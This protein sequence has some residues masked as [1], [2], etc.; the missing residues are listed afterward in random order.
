MEG[1]PERV[2]ERIPGSGRSRVLHHG[3]VGRRRELHALRRDLRQGRQLHVVQGL[4]GLGKS[5]FCIEALK[6]YRR[7]GRAALTLWCAE[8]ETSAVPTEGL[9][10]QLTAAAAP[11]AGADWEA[12]LAALDQAA[13]ADPALQSPARRLV[14]LL[15]WL[16]A[17]DAQPPLVLYLDNLESLLHRPDAEDGFGTWRDADCAALW[18]LLRALVGGAGGRLALLASCRYRHPD[19]AEA[20]FPLPR[21]PDETLWR[22]LGWFPALRRLSRWSREALVARI[23]GHPPAVEFLDALL[24]SA[25]TSHEEQHGDFVPAGDVSEA[26]A[27]WA[28]LIAPLLPPLSER[29]SADLLF[30]AL[31]ERVLDAPA[32][33]LLVRA[34]VLRRPADWEL[35]Q[36]LADPPDA[37][38]AIRRLRD[39]S[40]LTELTE[41]GSD[42]RRQRRFQVET[43]VTEFADALSTE[44]ERLRDEAHRRAVGEAGRALQRLER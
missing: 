14:A 32:R 13:A 8:V 36:A 11:L 24:C 18:R 41:T 33:R 10:R 43:S 31:W 21:L 15:Q 5:S 28:G 29:L 3:F 7:Q 25:L 40:L 4:G 23:G 44:L 6:V 22:L 35:L 17:R 37:D 16:L 39:T 1:P 19:Y 26:A 34:G 42:G 38:A 27:E 2:E 30:Q 20:L 9:L 12:T